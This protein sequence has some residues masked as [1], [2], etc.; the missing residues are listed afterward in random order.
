[1]AI[2]ADE[3][4]KLLAMP[5]VERVE[6]RPDGTVI[7]EKR[8]AVVVVPGY[9]PSPWFEPVVVPWW[10]PSPPYITYGAGNGDV[11]ATTTTYGTDTLLINDGDPA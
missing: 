10:V 5:D 4:A 8:R 1:M 7:V 6:L 2:S 11:V 3:I 9:T